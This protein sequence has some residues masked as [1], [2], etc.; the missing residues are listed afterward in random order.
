M[1]LPCNNVHQQIDRLTQSNVSFALYRLPWTDAPIMVLQ[2]RDTAESLY[3]L[4]ELNGKSG[5]ILSPFRPSA[6]HPIVR[7]RP[8]RR[9]R[10]WKHISRMLHDAIEHLP[11]FNDNTRDITSDTVGNPTEEELRQTYTEVFRRFITPLQAGKF[12]KLVLSRNAPQSLKQGFSPLSAFVNACNRYPRMMVS[13]CHTP[14]SG[15]W[16]GGTPEIILSGHGTE[17]HTVALAGTMPMEGETIPTQW[18]RK[19]RDEQAFVSDYIRHTVKCFS[20]KL[21]EKGPFT[22]R[23]GQL[24]H[25][26][27][28]FSFTLADPSHLGNI[29]KALHPTPAVCG[30]P[31]DEAYQ[32]INESEGYDRSYYAGIIGWL[33][34]SGETSLYVNLRCMH[35][36]QSHATFYA[37]GGILP[38]STAESEWEETQHK[39]NTMR[40]ILD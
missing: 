5:F 17:W 3:D 31:K 32:F 40:N 24:V 13:L 6:T 25:L 1:N 12:Q 33:D 18:S 4:S 11:Q 8:D 27:T 36:H 29:L 15:T 21:S 39:M 26:K 19:N 20:S 2:E 10:D 9:A 7:I 38:S 16:M 14:Q 34:P 35:L 37:G 22:A 23:A 28:E 30:L